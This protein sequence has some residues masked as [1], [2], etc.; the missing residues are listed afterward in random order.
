MVTLAFLI[1][2]VRSAE[3]LR[4]KQESE[5]VQEVSQET[6]DPRPSENPRVRMSL[7]IFEGLFLPEYGAATNCTEAMEDTIDQSVYHW[8][9][10]TFKQDFDSQD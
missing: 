6:V 10:R 5:E 9:N 1:L 7:S 8:K 4:L 2:L 3:E